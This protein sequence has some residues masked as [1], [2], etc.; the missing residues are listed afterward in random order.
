MNYRCRAL[1]VL[2]LLAIVC[3]FCFTASLSAQ[4][5]VY[6]PSAK[7][8]FVVR[9]PALPSSATSRLLR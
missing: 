1:G 3:A 2:A 5:P 6:D 7:P 4:E 9:T 8:M